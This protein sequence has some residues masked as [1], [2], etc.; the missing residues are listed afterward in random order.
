MAH[1]ALGAPGGHGARPAARGVLVGAHP[2]RGVDDG[3]QGEVLRQ[4]G[5][6]ADVDAAADGAASSRGMWLEL[7][8]GEL[9]KVEGAESQEE[10]DKEEEEEEEEGTEDEVEEDEDE[11]EEAAL[12]RIRVADIDT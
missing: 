9:G 6:V 4:L 12:S 10:E 7:S 5:Q 11:N 1:G 8:E 3:A 2:R